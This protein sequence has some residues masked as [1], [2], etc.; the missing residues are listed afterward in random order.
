MSCSGGEVRG[1]GLIAGVEV[2]GIV[3]RHCLGVLVD[4]DASG[5]C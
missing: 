5:C 2:S 4:V 3:G 1:D